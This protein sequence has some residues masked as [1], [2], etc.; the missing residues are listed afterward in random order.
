MGIG[1]NTMELALNVPRLPFKHHH[2]I[3]LLKA[4]YSNFIF[5]IFF[6]IPQQ[7][8]W[9]NALSPPHPSLSPLLRVQNDPTG[10]INNRFKN[11]LIDINDIRS[12][13]LAFFLRTD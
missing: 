12:P 13:L 1:I 11:K 8:K 7:Q 4:R 3:P 9:P 6:K 10:G 5:A 2:P